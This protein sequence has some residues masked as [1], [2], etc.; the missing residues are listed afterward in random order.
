[1]GRING[2]KPN[3]NMF[4]NDLNQHVSTLLNTNTYVYQNDKVVEDHKNHQNS[5][6]FVANEQ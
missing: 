6:M 4:A 5:K 2:L 1:M 3:Q